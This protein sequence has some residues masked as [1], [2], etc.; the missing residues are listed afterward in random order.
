MPQYDARASLAPRDIVSRA[1]MCEIKKSKSEY[2]YLDATGLS[3]S[4]IQKHFPNYTVSM[5][6]KIGY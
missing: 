6:T 3:V 2:V 1:I 4:T 5:S